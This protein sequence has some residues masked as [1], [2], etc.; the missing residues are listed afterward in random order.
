MYR[1]GDFSKMT[2]AS[3][4]TLRYY[5]EINLL[6]PNNIDNFT[7]YRY[8]TER[9]LKLFKRIEHLKKL[10]FTL[11]EIKENVDNL[12]LECL[13]L[14]KQELLLKVDYIMTQ[15]AGIDTLK[16]NLKS[17]KIKTLKK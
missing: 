3:V 8:Y 6:K 11:D 12:S 17:N 10:G 4:K 2:G 9:E 14:K 1:I 15:V 7:N 13:D 5:D 16:E